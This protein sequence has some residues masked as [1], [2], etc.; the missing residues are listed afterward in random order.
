MATETQARK[1][2]ADWPRVNLEEME[3]NSSAY[4]NFWNAMVDATEA[5]RSIFARMLFIAH[6]ALVVYALQTFICIQEVWVLMA[7]SV[8]LILEYVISLKI[9]YSLSW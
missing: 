4:V 9:E 3:D 8:L 7:L 1:S 5:F 6:L 2:F